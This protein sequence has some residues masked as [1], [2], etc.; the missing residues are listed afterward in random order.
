M[1]KYKY[2]SSVIIRVPYTWESEAR[3]TT[4]TH[5]LHISISDLYETESL[6]VIILACSFFLPKRNI[7]L[8]LLSQSVFHFANIFQTHFFFVIWKSIYSAK[9]L[10][11]DGIL[12]MALCDITLFLF[13]VYL[14]FCVRFYFKEIL[15][16]MKAKGLF[17]HMHVLT[18]E[19]QK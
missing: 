8:L 10:L 4:Y 16:S 2:D 7:F 12:F 15:D 13:V 18:H 19:S 5:K 3:P 9:V 17:L 1:N 11:L 14:S 6:I